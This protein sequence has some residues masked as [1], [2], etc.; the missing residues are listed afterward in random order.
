MWLAYNLKRH[1][2]G[3]PVVQAVHGG[4]VDALQRFPERLWLEELSEDMK[5]YQFK[6][7]ELEELVRITVEMHE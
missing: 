2:P 7:E 1:R 6:E 3:S 4:S 5:R